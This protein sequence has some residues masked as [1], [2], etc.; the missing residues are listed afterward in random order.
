[1]HPTH[2]L[3][4]AH[5]SLRGLAL[6][7]AFG[8]SFFGDEDAVLRA[9]A[10]R[11]VPAATRWEFTDDTVMAIAVVD[12]LARYGRIEP[13]ALARRFAENYHL[14]PRR[15]YGA[16]AHRVLREIGEGRPWREVSAA[17][18]D[19]QGSMGNG[20]AMRAAP[21]GAYFH[22]DAARLIEQATLSAEVTHLNAEGVAGAVAVALAAGLAVRL[23]Q[24][25]EVLRGEEFI[26]GVYQQLPGGTDTKAKIGKARSLPGSYRVA[27]AAAVLGNG[28]RLLAQ[29]TVPF[30]L[31]VIAHRLDNFAA[32]LWT[33]VAALG[34]R[35]TIGA[36]VGS[37]V[38]LRADA[39]TV[40]ADWQQAVESVD[41]S[42]FWGRV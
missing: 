12:V 27:T 31:W 20:A 13:D 38:S 5:Q 35:D 42:S 1:M 40:P 15:G 26:D 8:D 33:A 9:I 25:G 3:H 18:F 10:A 22:D 32:A 16:T 36:I 4:L 34:D 30:A 28:S 11:R 24:A 14:D 7:D 29:D 17:V 6:G 23:G 41:E 19:G 21:I 2:R 37:V 39:A